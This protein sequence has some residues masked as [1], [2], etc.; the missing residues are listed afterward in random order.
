VHIGDGEQMESI[1]NLCSNFKANIEFEL[2]G[3]M[4]NSEISEFYQRNQ[5]H[6]FIHLS[7][8]EGGVPVVLQEAGMAGIPLM[9][10][11]VGGVSEIVNPVTGILVPSIFKVDEIS[12]AIK[13]FLDSEKN[14]LIYRD[15]VRNF[16]K[17]NF[18]EEVNHRYFISN[19]F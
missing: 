6:L 17:D 3:R 15:G 8:S 11:D 4:S 10:V 19:I 5:V 2:K 9:A 7:E 12:S 18:N 14:T 1:K 16:I 13:S